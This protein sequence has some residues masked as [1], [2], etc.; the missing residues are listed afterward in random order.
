M[1]LQLGDRGPDS[2]GVAIYRNP[3]P[4]GSCKVTLHSP[5][6]GYDWAGVRAALAGAFGAGDARCARA[7]P[8]SWSRRDADE[9]RRLA[10]RALPRAAG[11]ERRRGDR[12]L[13]GGGPPGRLPRALR[14]RRAVAAVT[15]WA[16][17]GWRPSRRSRPT[18]RTRSRPASTCASSTTARSPTTTGCASGCAPRASSSRPRTTPRSPPATSPGACARARRS[19]RRSRAASRTS[20]AST[21]SRS[22]RSTAS[23]CCATRSPASPR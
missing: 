1:L 20:T 8:S 7:T 3:A 22:A 11:D 16:T 23:R 18:A 19:S 6:P 10:A 21:P 17:R 5:A 13:Q 9:R 14:V 15:R 12:D 2:A 4:S